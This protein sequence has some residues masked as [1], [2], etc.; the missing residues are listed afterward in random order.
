MKTAGVNY[1]IV[2][3]YPASLGQKEL[4]ENL[5]QV[6]KQLGGGVKVS[7]ADWGEKELA[8]AIEGQLKAKFW[9][10][11]LTVEEGTDVDWKNLKT[12]LNRDKEILR[13]LILKV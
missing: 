9:I 6:E 1:Q 5:A 13:Y 11:K 10:G 4:K 12:Y 2:M 7:F 8:Y 3:E